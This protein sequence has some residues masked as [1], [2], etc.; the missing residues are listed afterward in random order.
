MFGDRHIPLEWKLHTQHQQIH[1]VRSECILWVGAPFQHPS[2]HLSPRQ[3][4]SHLDDWLTSSLLSLFLSLSTFHGMQRHPVKVW[5]ISCC[6]STQ[7]PLPHSLMSPSLFR[8]NTRVFLTMY[9]FH[10]SQP[11]CL[12]W[13]HPLTSS[14]YHC[15]PSTLVFLLPTAK[16]FAHPVPLPGKAPPKKALSPNTHMWL[17]LKH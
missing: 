13:P 9:K 17:L 4:T 5:I 1:Q 10:S 6:F 8:V 15:V 3:P 12:F 14:P 2:L 16:Y 7:Q 11:P